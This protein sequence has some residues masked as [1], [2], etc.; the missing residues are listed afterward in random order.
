[1]QKFLID[2]INLSR[3]PIIV[4]VKHTRCNQEHTIELE[5]EKI[6]KDKEKNANLLA[7]CFPDHLIPFPPPQW[8]MVYLF[9]PGNMNYLMSFRGDEFIKDFDQ[10]YGSFEAALANIPPDTYR[11]QQENPE[12]I[13]EMRE[14]VEKEDISKYP[15]TFQLARNL[16]TQAWKTTK[17]AIST[18]QLLVDAETA[19]KRYSTC[20]GCPF[21]NLKDKRCTECGCFMEQ[22]VHLQAA[23][24]PKDKW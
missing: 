19:Q 22:K 11:A 14:M 8:N 13:E 7:Y 5:I 12:I 20:E 4:F 9:E 18:G 1:M 15:S 10:M 23:E 16:F 2:S 6:I 24:C 21:F 17:E 3:Y